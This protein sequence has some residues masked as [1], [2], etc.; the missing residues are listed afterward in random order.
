ML[1]IRSSLLAAVGLVALACD[2][3]RASLEIT[4]VHA[5]RGED[6]RVIIDVELRAS[7]NMGGNIGTYCTQ[8]TF[9]GQADPAERCRTDLEDGDTATV[10]VISDGDVPEGGAINIRVRHFGVDIRRDLGAPKH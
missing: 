10:R 2:G 6:R 4:G 3:P 1:C 9:A 7:E 5:S 8:V